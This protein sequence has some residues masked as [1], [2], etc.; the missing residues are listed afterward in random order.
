[1]HKYACYFV[2]NKTDVYILKVDQK[3]KEISE[4]FKTN[5]AFDLP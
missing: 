2:N 1:M 5:S 3:K 4:D